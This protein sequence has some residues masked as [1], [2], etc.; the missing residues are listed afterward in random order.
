MMLRDL[1]EAIGEIWFIAAEM[2][3]IMGSFFEVI[4]NFSRPL[5]V[6]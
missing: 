6:P 1:F 4:D 3:S 2:V 5:G